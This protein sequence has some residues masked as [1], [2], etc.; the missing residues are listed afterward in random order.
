MAPIAPREFGGS[1]RRKA[2][3]IPPRVQCVGGG[4][5]DI[6]RGH[7]RTI[8]TS[9]AAALD[10][11]LAD[12]GPL[13]ANAQLDNFGHTVACLTALSRF[14]AELRFQLTDRSASMLRLTERAL[15]HL[16]RS[17]VADADVRRKWQEAFAAGETS[18][19]QLGAAHLLLHGIWA[20]KTSAAGERTDLVYGEPVS[21]ADISVAA[22][23][24]L[25]LTEW[26]L[27]RTSSELAA[28][29]GLA[30]AQARLYSRGVLGGVELL[31]EPDEKSF[32]AA[33]VAEPVRLFVL[34]YVADELRASLTEP[35]ERLVDVV[36]SEH[37]A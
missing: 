5:K 7:G 35:G 28:K 13:L 26:K 18:C 17:I 4:Y 11:F 15:Q 30:E 20:F 37:D 32:G 33:D 14:R 1:P 24:A 9:A 3:D 34:N 21:E 31:G 22:A 12:H 36:H 2:T 23:D 16:Q 6:P 19:E 10:R 27:V 25:V 29:L 8:P